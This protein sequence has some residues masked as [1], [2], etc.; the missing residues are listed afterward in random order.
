MKVNS[1]YDAPTPTAFGS[2]VREDYGT[3][4]E[5]GMIHGL[6][7]RACTT[8]ADDAFVAGWNAGRKLR[9]RITDGYGLR[10]SI[11]DPTSAVAHAHATDKVTR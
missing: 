3:I 4:R 1:K 10:I 8:N 6:R 9:S 2:S 5:L 11:D 7:G